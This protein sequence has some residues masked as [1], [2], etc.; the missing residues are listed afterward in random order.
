MSWPIGFLHWLTGV[1]RGFVGEA[2]GTAWFGP[3]MAS[4][5]RPCPTRARPR[6]AA[7]GVQTAPRTADLEPDRVVLYASLARRRRR[8]QIVARH[9]LLADGCGR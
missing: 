8:A 1:H 4:P 2:A 6:P 5:A 3:P 7:R 9:L